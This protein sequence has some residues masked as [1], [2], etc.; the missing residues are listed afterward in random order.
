MSLRTQAIGRARTAWLGVMSD[1]CQIV[2][3][4]PAWDDAGEASTPRTP[5]KEI[6]CQFTPAGASEAKKSD[7]SLAVSTAQVRFP[8]DTYVRD[9]DRVLL[10]SRFGQPVDPALSFDVDGEPY[11]TPGYILCNLREVAT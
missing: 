7:G 8:V 10:V 3:R 1:G 9:A 6:T 2:P 4:Y 5:T 11:L